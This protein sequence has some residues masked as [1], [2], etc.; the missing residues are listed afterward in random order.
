MSTNLNPIFL[1]GADGRRYERLE[2]ILDDW[3]DGALFQVYRGHYASCADIL[4]MRMAGFTHVCFVW[5]TE[6]L[7]V[8][9]HFLDLNEYRPP[10]DVQQ[11]EPGAPS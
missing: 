9:G 10:S 1:Y 8:H 2:Q 3:N 4:R 6:D 11:Y 7:R 5:Q